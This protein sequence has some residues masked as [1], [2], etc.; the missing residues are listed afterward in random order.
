MDDFHSLYSGLDA[1]FF[2]Q[3]SVGVHFQVQVLKYQQN[4]M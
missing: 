2:L 4:Q 1:I 3:F